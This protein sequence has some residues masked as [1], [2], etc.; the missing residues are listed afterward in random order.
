MRDWMKRMG[1]RIKAWWLALL[2][3]LGLVA[4]PIIYAEIV[5]FTYTAATERVDGSPLDIAD[6]AFTRLYCDGALVVEEPGADQTFNPELGLGSHSCHATH[7]DT[8]GQESGPSN[9]VVKVVNPALP[10][11]PVLDP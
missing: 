11:P 8:D 4:A 2:I 5:D 6:I 7:V 3:G 1:Q 9:I 10:S